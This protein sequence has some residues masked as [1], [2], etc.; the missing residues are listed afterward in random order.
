MEKLS[1]ANTRGRI[2]RLSP[3]ASLDVKKFDSLI[4]APK[5]S[6]S[7]ALGGLLSPFRMTAKFRSCSVRS[8]SASPEIWAGPSEFETNYAA[9]TSAYVRLGASKKYPIGRPIRMTFRAGSSILPISIHRK[10]IRWSSN[11]RLARVLPCFPLARERRFALAL[12]A[13]GYFVLMPKPR[14]SFGQGEAFTRANVRDFGYGD[15]SRYFC[16]RR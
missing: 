8:F 13:S 10:N 5:L 4:I 7:T 6:V 3:L 16:P 9:Q 11:S 15:P 2:L 1:P 12:A 14:G